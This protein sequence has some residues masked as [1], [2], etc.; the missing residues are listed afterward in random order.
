[1]NEHG[2]GFITI[3]VGDSLSGYRLHFLLFGHSDIGPTAD[4]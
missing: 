3:P 2:K 1:M 4:V